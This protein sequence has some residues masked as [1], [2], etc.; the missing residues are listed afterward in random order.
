MKKM[1][2]RVSAILFVMIAVSC[3][4]PA[5]DAE[6]KS[7]TA[8]EWHKDATIYEVNIRQYTEEGTFD[9]FREHLPRLKELGVDILWLMP[10]HPIGEKKR[11]GELGS[12]Y[13]VKDYKAVNPEFGTDEDFQNLVDAAHEQGFHLILDWVA[14][15]TAWDNYMIEENPE[16]YTRDSAGN[17][18]SPYDWSD[19]AD[20]NYDTPELRQYMKG[21]LKYWVEEFDVDGYRCDVA[22]MVPVDFWE[23]A[24]AELNEVKPVFMLAEDEDNLSLLDSAFQMHYGWEFHHV[25]NQVAQGEES[26]NA[27]YNYFEKVDTTIG[28]SRKMHFLTNHDENSW[29]GTIEER[30]G[31]ASEA[32]AV[33]SFTIPG[34]PLIYSGQEI[35]LN[36]QL[37]FFQKDP[38]A[39]EESPLEDFYATLNDLKAENEALYFGDFGGSFEILKS[40]MPE[41]TFVFKRVKNDNEVLV[42]TNLSDETQAF[43]V[44]DVAGDYIN[45]FTGEKEALDRKFQMQ[46]WDYAVYIKE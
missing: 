16:W 22:G 11:K 31:D 14:N 34:M 44:P 40:D 19:V 37:E 36:K 10:I 46:P 23:D 30:M 26:V 2:T 3:S 32:M 9:A 13:S 12:Y 18:V 21:A 17:M 33:I 39:W 43:A 45:Y 25:M 4:Q 6:E 1:F 29:N 42:V 24:V 20:L 7:N 41:N 35:G 38:I 8:V 5:K 15:H 28:H 27:F